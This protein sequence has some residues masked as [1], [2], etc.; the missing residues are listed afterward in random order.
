[1]NLLNDDSSINT[2]K[3]ISLLASNEETAPEAR[4]M[5]IRLL[6]SEEFSSNERVV[7]DSLCS[8]LG[9]YPYIENI[10]SQGTA[11]IL[12]Y[13]FHRPLD[14][15]DP[16]LHFHSA[17]H[18][19]YRRIMD[20]Q[21][22]I[23][24]APTSFGKS[25]ILDSLLISGKWANVVVIVPTIALIDETRRRISHLGL[26]SRIITQVDQERGESN[27]FVLTQE[28][29]LEIGTIPV[30]LFIIDEFY[31]L[32]TEDAYGIRKSLLNLA[33]R[34]L[35]DT[36][37][38]FYMI[39]PNIECLDAR[40]PELQ[41]TMTTSD[42]RTVS[43]NVDDRSECSDP[44][45][46]VID[47]VSSRQLEPTLMFSA[48]PSKADTLAAAVSSGIQLQSGHAWAK[49]VSS[50]LSSE[51]DGG[52]VVAKTL[53]LGVGT[54]YGPMPRS[55]QRIMVRLFNENYIPALVC[56]STL[57]EGVNTSA[58]NVVI[59]DKKID[60]V[61][62]DSFTF[63]NIKGR[64]GRMLKHFVGNVITYVKEPPKSRFELDIPIE[65]QSDDASLSTLV[66]LNPSDIN[67]NAVER[68]RHIF[69][70]TDIKLE[71][72]RENRG[73][74]PDLQ[75]AA[76]RHL[77][78]SPSDAR[79]LGWSGMPSTRDLRWTL[80]FAFNHLAISR[81]KQGFN[82]RIVWGMLQNVRF[83]ALSFS[84]QV[85]NQMTYARGNQDRNDIVRA[86]LSF[87]RNWMGFTIPSL[88]RGLQGIQ[89]DV[90]RKL[91]LPAG[92][93]ELA[94]RE[95]ENLYLPNGIAKLEEF[96]L[97]IPLSA[98]LIEKGLYGDNI[99]ALLGRLRVLSYREEV[100][101]SLN[102]V[103]LWILDDV[104]EGLG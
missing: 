31:K 7:V 14:R 76:A 89:V 67:G 22:V 24:S 29:Y 46:D 49:A 85:D 30:D 99:D 8:A 25:A 70:Q 45:A 48:S 83:N 43:V 80:E 18:A 42:F 63:A 69:E 23:L 38:Q 73:L 50:W 10:G 33:W 55:T 28:R 15:Q 3:R 95:I 64:A 53:S 90:A 78:A 2:L 44:V 12:A 13:E 34:R 65:T 41:A 79:R 66:H 104:V 97:P 58:K 101:Q 77:L 57:I 40:L 93:Y 21:D 51:Y 100:R 56:T 59:F 54:H 11:S 52:W 32:G 98:K 16:K 81:Q 27:V 62:M 36:G 37:A 94:I 68:S 35:S 60:G 5:L 1:M 74:D 91:E 88:L 87:Q 6:D 20:G 72:L 92:N 86:V 84:T 19:I 39:G 96:G 103:E 26:A 4:D 75:I 61:A 82:P 9:L 17:Q 47:F 102:A 71:T